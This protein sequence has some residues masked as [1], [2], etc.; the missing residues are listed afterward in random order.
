MTYERGLK[1][2]PTSQ[3]H[4]LSLK[5]EIKPKE[6]L[7][8]DIQENG[9]LTSLV[10]RS[11]GDGYEVIDGHRRLKIAK[12]QGFEELPCLV[13][14]ECNKGDAEALHFS[15]NK[16]PENPEPEEVL[17]LFHELKQEDFE[18]KDMEKLFGEE[19]YQELEEFVELAE[20]KKVTDFN[21]EEF[22]DHFI[23]DKYIKAPPFPVV[24]NFQTDKRKWRFKEFLRVF[25]GA[26]GNERARNMMDE[27]GAD[28]LC[29][30][31]NAQQQVNL[32]KWT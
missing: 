32:R 24:L 25:E 4:T 21:L 28:E 30:P 5:D 16:L 31:E 26:T 11:I 3:L 9:V 6:S 12:N 23:P 22:G 29:K 10:V 15:L 18:Q 20:G 13:L 14:K 27:L 19:V 1:W 17:D 7:K 8:T 2:I